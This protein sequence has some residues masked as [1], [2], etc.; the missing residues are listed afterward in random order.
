MRINITFTIPAHIIFLLFEQKCVANS[1]GPW[2]GI[3]RFANVQ[4]YL[5]IITKKFWKNNFLSIFKFG[6]TGICSCDLRLC[7]SYN[8]GIYGCGCVVNFNQ[9]QCCCVLPDEDEEGEE[10]IWGGGRG[11]G[12]QTVESFFIRLPAMMG[13]KSNPSPRHFLRN[14]LNWLSISIFHPQFFSLF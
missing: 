9:G 6:K 11:W 3:F 7:L 5:I 13:R 8:Y 1:T 2:V 10:K 14:G 4:I 12:R